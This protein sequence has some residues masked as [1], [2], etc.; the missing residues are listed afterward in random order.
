VLS[1]AQSSLIDLE[2]LGGYPAFKIYD[3]DPDTFEV[4]DVKVYMSQFMAP[5]HWTNTDPCSSE[6]V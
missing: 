2:N 5:L 4:M 6:Y 3:V 1:S